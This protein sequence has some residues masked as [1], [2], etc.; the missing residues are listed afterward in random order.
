MTILWLGLGFA[1]FMLVL[2]SVH[3]VNRY[4]AGRWG[5]EP[6]SAPNTA[7]MLVPSGLLLSLLSRRAELQAL[8]AGG[9]VGLGVWGLF[10]VGLLALVTRRTNVWVGLYAALLLSV[11]APVVFFALLYRWLVT[12][13]A[14]AG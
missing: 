4:A 8:D 2:G 12:P 10:L 3:L 7:L 5:Y 1:V 13:D 9:M 14:H 11:A 6:F